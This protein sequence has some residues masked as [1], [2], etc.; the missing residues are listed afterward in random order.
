ML[1]ESLALVFQPSIN[2][3]TADVVAALS[4]EMSAAGDPL[5]SIWTELDNGKKMTV[6]VDEAITLLKRHPTFSVFQAIPQSEIG[7]NKN[8]WLS[9]AFAY[10][11]SPNAKTLIFG[12]PEQD[13]RAPFSRHIALLREMAA[14]GI[15]PE[16]GFG[17]RREYGLGPM[18]F[19]MGHVLETG[20]RKASQSDWVRIVAW[21]AETSGSRESSKRYRYEKGLMLDVFPLNVLTDVHLDQHVAGSTLHDWIVQETGPDSL[22]QIADRC[23]VWSVPPVETAR[24]SI[25]L[26]GSGLIIATARKQRLQ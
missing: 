14:R 3:G 19:A 26:D 22:S 7:N 16:Y 1:S 17:F 4:S 24:L 10:N 13:G 9:A 20:D 2:L 15:A 12:V 8:N 5:Q 11:V 21:N 6:A 18:H 25:A 23:F